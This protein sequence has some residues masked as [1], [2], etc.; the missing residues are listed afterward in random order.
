MNRTAQ[1]ITGIALALLQTVPVFAAS[2]DFHQSPAAGSG[3]FIAFAIAYLS[4]RRAIGGWLLYFYLQ[5]YLSL[6]ISLLFMPQVIS[7]LKPSSWDNALLYVMFFLS[8]VP[9]LA[10]ELIEVFAATRLLVRRSEANLNFLRWTLVALVVASIV[11]VAIDLV[12]FKEDTAIVFDFIT[13][14]FAVIWAAYFRKA[15]RVRA[16][17]IEKNWAYDPESTKRIL[18]AEDKK[19]LRRRVLIA[20]SVTFVLFLVIMG[21]TLQ[22]D[23]KAPDAGIFF[24]PLF[25]AVIAAIV[26]WYLPVRKKKVMNAAAEVTPSDRNT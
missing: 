6:L 25:C 23:G 12:W 14:F 13:A 24:V 10:I 16:V 26:A 8:V 2:A 7:N 18:T 15:R 20:S 3:L 21:S 1:L 17:F 4:R 22:Q 19:K 9:V 5:L 11:S